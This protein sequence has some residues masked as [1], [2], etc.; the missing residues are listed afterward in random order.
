[1]IAKAT[2]EGNTYSVG[3]NPS[4]PDTIFHISVNEIDQFYIDTV[5]K[6]LKYGGDLE[7]VNGTLNNLTVLG[8]LTNGT[9]QSANIIGGIIKSSNYVANTSGMLINLTTGLIDSPNFKLSDMGIITATGGNFSGNISGSTITG[10]TIKSVFGDETQNVTMELSNTSFTTYRTYDGVIDYSGDFTFQGI[11]FMTPFPDY[12]YAEY[13]YSSI[14]IQD[15]VRDIF[16]VDEFG[17]KVLGSSVL[18]A[19]NLQSY[20]DTYYYTKE[21][22]N[23]NFAPKIH[24]HSYASIGDLQDLDSSLRSWVS[25][26]FVAK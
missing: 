4:T 1:M 16:S 24:Y 8:T 18:T 5:N 23:S 3:I 14:K 2:L 22:V 25:A 6:K 20:T 11:S 13:T 26:N 19:N 7:A 9:F 17:A 12:H 21:Y 10:T 15:S